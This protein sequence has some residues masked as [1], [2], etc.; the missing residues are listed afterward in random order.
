MA[1]RKEA[2][3]VLVAIFAILV[4]PAASAYAQPIPKPSIPEFT[5]Q[6]ADNSYV[7]SASTSIDPFTG[8]TVTNHAQSVNNQTIQIT[9]KNQTIPSASYLFYEVRMKGHY[10]QEWTNIS[11]VQADP[12]SEFT[13]LVYA[14][15]GNNASGHFTSTLHEV[16]SAG[17]ADFQVQTQIWHYEQS[18]DIFG[19]WNQVLWTASDWSDAQTITIPRPALTSFA[20]LAYSPSLSLSPS[21]TCSPV[22]L[23]TSSLKQQ[24]TSVPSKSPNKP[25]ENLASIAV[26]FGAVIAIVIV[27]GLLAYVSKSRVLTHF[28]HRVLAL[29]FLGRAKKTLYGFQTRVWPAEGHI[30]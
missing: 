3:T 20:S 8:K 17:T 7:I 23:P 5:V 26:V 30:E 2:L 4:S 27:V 9:I 12:R 11:F 25:Q 13:V 29:S 10:S 22:N 28:Q 18:N 14:I 1:M 24:P 21:A 15:D 6:Y 16:S 19:S